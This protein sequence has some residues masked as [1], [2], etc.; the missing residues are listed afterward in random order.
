M[1]DDDEEGCADSAKAGS[2]RSGAKKQP[3][4]LPST[5]RLGR[6]RVTEDV[7]DDFVRSGLLNASLRSYSWASG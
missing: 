4:L 2:V 1:D 6:S 7:L 5:Y 3:N